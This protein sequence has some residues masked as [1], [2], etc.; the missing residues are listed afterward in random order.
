[1]SVGLHTTALL[2]KSYSPAHSVGTM[3]RFQMKSIDIQLLK[4]LK[5]Y[6]REFVAAIDSLGHQSESYGKSI[7]IVASD[8]L[9]VAAFFGNV[10]GEVKQNE[11]NFIHDIWKA[12]YEDDA[13]QIQSADGRTLYNQILRRFP[14][15]II[16]A[17]HAPETVR[18][19]REYDRQ[20]GTALAMRAAE[21][22][23]ALAEDV[24]DVDGDKD[25]FESILLENYKEMLAVQANIAYDGDH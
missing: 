5:R 25:I 22:F 17:D 10:D 8:Y 21:L 15:K 19:L 13:P 20:H 18:L 7:D 16:T 9:M 1:M 2:Q 24:S 3:E 12:F 14:G 11:L 23:A 4:N 6:A